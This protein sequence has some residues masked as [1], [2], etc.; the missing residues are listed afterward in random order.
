MTEQQTDIKRPR[1]IP[2]N[3]LDLN[4]MTINTEWGSD[5]IPKELIEK[6]TQYNYKFI[7]DENSKLIKDANG[8]PIMM[9]DAEG[10]PIIDKAGLWQ[11]L[12][13]YTRDIRLGNLSKQEMTY[14]QYYLDLAND[15]LRVNYIE[16]F[17]ICLSRTIT[18][19]EL[20]QSKKGFLRQVMQTLFEHKTSINSEPKK[21]NIFGLGKSEAN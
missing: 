5:N 6:L 19:L 10:K 8:N 13:F 18:I 15:D 7:R 16:A 12:G 9:G 20:S 3:D 1:Q 21:R 17:L 11:L 4:L 14:C 2:Q